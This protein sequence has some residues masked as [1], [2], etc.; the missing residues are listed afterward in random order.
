M[1]CDAVK[2]S[3]MS[4]IDELEDFAMGRVRNKSGERSD[5]STSEKVAK[6]SATKS[7]R[8]NEAEDASR[9]NQQ[10]GGDDLE[11]FFNT[12]SR[13]SSVPRSRAATS[14]GTIDVTIMT[15]FLASIRLYYFLSHALFRTLYLMHQNTRKA[16]K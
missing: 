16:L 5:V 12:S 2:N 4:S 8:Y 6:N 9:R 15:P 10:K 13:S 11:S 7:S 1:V 14:V 3:S